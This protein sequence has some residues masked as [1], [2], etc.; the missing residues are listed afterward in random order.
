MKRLVILGL[1]LIVLIPF[2]SFAEVPLRFGIFPVYKP[3]T[4]VKMFKLISEQIELQTGI[5]VQLVT[6]P[7]RNDFDERA[8]RGEY[9]IIWSSNAGFFKIR[10]A[11]GFRI[12]AG[13]E[14]TFT[15]VVM[16]RADS[17]IEAVE[18]LE[19][20]NIVSTNPYSLAGY[21]FFRN[22]M[23]EKNLFIDQDYTVSFNGNIEALPFLVI[24][25]KFDAVVFSEDTY[26][27]SEIYL[28][29][30]DQLNI[31]AR[32]ID[33]P[34]FPFA[35]SPEIDEHTAS[36]IRSVLTSITKDTAEGRRI[37][38]SLKLDRIV[39]KNN[40]D[41]KEFEELYLKIKSNAMRNEN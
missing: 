17:G 9:D 39:V 15:G 27:Q 3:K 8:I 19:G 40:S 21:L 18:D 16:V 32:S 36:E 31:I 4:I 30:H 14:P 38:D 20:C 34:Q 26:L 7:S 25:R 22:M 23:S 6:A 41:Y 33:I 37:L 1:L 2:S 35:V 5:P 11:A 24:N 13:G 29:T 28:Q 10:D 12:I